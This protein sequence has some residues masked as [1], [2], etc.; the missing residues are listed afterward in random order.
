MQGAS[1]LTG[2]MRF[3]E[4]LG[5]LRRR[6]K[7][8]FL[9]L[10]VFLVLFLLVPR[11][12]SQ[13]LSLTGTY[14]PLVSIFL[15]RIVQDILPKTWTL[16]GFRLNEPLEVLLVASLVLAVAFDAPVIAYEVYRFI[17]PALK[18]NEKRLVYPF[19]ASSTALFLVG[20]GFGY[21]FLARFI[22]I[23]LSPFFVATHASFVIDLADFYF[24]IFLSVFFS[25]VA[26]TTPVFVFLLI[27]FGILDP[28]FF[29]RNRVMIWFGTYIVTAVITP[30]G[31]PVLDLILFVPVIGL[32]ELSVFL[33]RRFSGR[34]QVAQ[35]DGR[36]CR[37]C[38]TPLDSGTVFCGNCGRVNS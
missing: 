36:L 8:V 7:I 31:G 9:S 38:G 21:F 25:G 13:F 23:A 34:S 33:A 16:I 6:L 5:E 11:D 1:T 20:L 26:F 4:H 35:G 37:Y 17:D 19:V 24:V 12:P 29:S 15:D 30:D 27:K 18:E 14:S 3:T 22:I 32:L 28:S 2:E 10:L